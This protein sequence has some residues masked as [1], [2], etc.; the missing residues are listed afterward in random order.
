M[1]TA[2]PATRVASHPLEPLNSQEIAA[3]VEILG[4]ERRL[5]PRMRFVTITL[6]EPP[7]AAVL[8]YQPGNMLDREAFVILF[9]SE[10]GQTYEALVSLTR[11]T[12]S[13]WTHVPDV[14]PAI[15]LDEFVECEAGVQASP[16]W[17]AAMRKRGVDELRPV[18]GRSLVG[19][20]LRI[21]RR[22]GPCGCR[23]R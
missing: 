23:G 20:Q 4:A 18:H 9:D 21:A 14:Q 3:A 2:L 13:A 1:A 8:A 10:T 15:M 11:Q 17:Q 16:E 6:N 22:T 7:K 19:R 5:G 12:V